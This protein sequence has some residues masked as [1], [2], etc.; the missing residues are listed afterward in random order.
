M[1]VNLNTIPMMA[2]TNA[3]GTSTSFVQNLEDSVFSDL[4]SN[5]SSSFFNK[6]YKR[7]AETLHNDIPNTTGNTSF[8][9]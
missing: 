8:G 2:E 5:S 3:L 1:R 4:F 9:I 7:K 6:I